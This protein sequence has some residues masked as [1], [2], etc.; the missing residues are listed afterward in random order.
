M[1]R[2]G[3]IVSSVP[4]WDARYAGDDYLFGTDPNPF[5][6]SAAERIAPG[7]RVLCIADGEG[8]NG[9]WL[10]QRGHSVD[11]FDP[12]PVAVAKARRLA[13]ARG[14]DVRMQVADVDG[15]G[16][17]ADTYDAV[18]A[19]FVQF[20]P[21]DMRRRMF[22]RVARALHPGG[23]FLLTGYRDAQ[24]AYGTGGP[25]VPEQLYT[26]EMLRTELDEAGLAVESLRAHDTD[27]R[28]G[29]QHVGMSA[30]VDV[31]ARR[32]ATG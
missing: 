17:P 13:A 31:V 22:A 15:W 1:A 25:R 2:H 18:V 10:A 12:S 7:G 5:L 27:V 26:E 9:V 29:T 32:P 3:R 23:V 11:T 21:P 4:H 14:V 19:V 6:V 8:R 16:W 20:A 30:L 28:E 24:L